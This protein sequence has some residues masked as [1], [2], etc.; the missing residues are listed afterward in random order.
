[1]NEIDLD[2]E[3]AIEEQQKTT[4]MKKEE[5]LG[6]DDIQG[7]NWVSAPRVGEKTEVLTITKMIK[8][9]NIDAKDKEGNPF[10][11]NLSSVD[12][13]IDIHTDK[14]IYSPGSWEAWGKIKAMCRKAEAT[15]GIKF[16]VEHVADGMKDKKAQSA[17]KCYK[18]VWHKTD[19]TTEE[20]F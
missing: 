13:K 5:E 2:V 17:K 20:F 18:I 1:M 6:I 8:N 7:G 16:S 12:W 4:P 10:K 14:G 11:T 19:G 15:K 3:K 9:Y